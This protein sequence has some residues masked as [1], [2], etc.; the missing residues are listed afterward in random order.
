M[1]EQE[2]ILERAQQEST[3][4]AARATKAEFENKALRSRIQK[5][6]EALDR[7]HEATGDSDEGNALSDIHYWLNGHPTFLDIALGKEREALE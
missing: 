3:F 1:T 6:S 5:A 4:Y 2:K 7:F